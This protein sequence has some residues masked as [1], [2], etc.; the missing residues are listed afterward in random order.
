[1]QHICP[2]RKTCVSIIWSKPRLS[3]RPTSSRWC[4]RDERPTTNDERPP[5]TDH[6]PPT[7]R[8]GS[9]QPTAHPFTPSHLHPFTDQC[10]TYHELNRRANQL[11]HQLRA[12]D[13]GPEM[14]VGICVE[15]S[16][17]LVVGLLGILKAGAAY[18]PL[19]PAYPSQRLAFML[20]N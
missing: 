4:S 16:L 6:R 15:R 2:I 19:D 17:E 14:H 7:L 8:L 12:L 5:T 3:G 1:M 13:I 18:V 11:A 20:Q 9:W 10:L